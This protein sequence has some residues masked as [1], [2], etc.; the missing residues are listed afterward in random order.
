MPRV[1]YRYPA[2]STDAVADRIRA[3]RGARGLTPLDGMLLNAP[4]VAD[5]WNTFVG[6][7]RT[8]TSLRDDL[9]ELM[10]LR[11]AA[12]N[13]AAFEWIHHEHVA[14]KAGLSYEQLAVIGHVAA[15]SSSNDT[16]ASQPDQARGEKLSTLQT[17][18]LDFADASTRHVHI[19]TSIFET[20]KE[21][22]S[23]ELQRSEERT[24]DINGGEVT[25]EQQIV[26]AAAVVGGYNLVSRFLV[27]LDVDDKAELFV[28]IPR[29]ERISIPVGGS[30]KSDSLHTVGSEPG[31]QA[32]LHAVY[33]PRQGDQ[34]DKTLVFVNSL[35]TNYRMW[36]YTWERLNRDYN[37]VFYDQRGHGGS[38]APTT[39]GEFNEEGD[40]KEGG[41]EKCTMDMLADDLLAV[42]EH[43]KIEKAHAVIGI[44]QG[45][46]TTLNFALRYPS[47]AGKVVAGATQAKSPE[48]NIKAWDERIQLAREEGMGRLADVTIPRWFAEG[49]S[50]DKDRDYGW[51]KQ[52]VEG[53]TVEG[54]AYSAAALQGYDLL[55]AGLVDALSKRPEGTTMLLAGEMDGKLPDGLKALG[56]EVEEAGGSV[57]VEVVPRGGHLP[58]VNEPEAF[59]DVLCEFLKE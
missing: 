55:A 43:F 40:G 36:R 6:G 49:S 1:P 54:F 33:L 20:F 30:S 29:V 5:G 47:R 16:D 41:K 34:T 57:R 32:S 59:L 39:K 48:A 53:T 13:N 56:R 22:L 8:R 31:S 23:S 15:P 28:P 12:C 35:L 18:A 24:K 19:P 27:A 17:A 52:G 50:F 42:L 44:S 38:Y 26:E 10:I 11:V 9:R 2:P 25:A 37:L 58:C 46:A 21:H 14:R 45:G 3:R 51:L 7:L 4:N